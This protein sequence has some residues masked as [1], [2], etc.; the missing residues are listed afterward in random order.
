[1]L[2]GLTLFG[3]SLALLGCL[4]PSKYEKDPEVGVADG[5]ISGPLDAARF[6]L[7]G[8]PP[9]V[10]AAPI[11]DMNL[12]DVGDDAAVIEDDAS[13]DEGLAEDVQ[14][15]PDSAPAPTEC[16]V[17]FIVQVP[18][19][20]DGIYIAGDMTD[21]EPDGAQMSLNGQEARLALTLPLGPTAYKY[22]R[23]SWETV[24]KT[25]E[26]GEQENRPQNI[27][28]GPDGIAPPVIDQVHHW[29]DGC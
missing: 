26:C 24:E 20:T 13:L 23:G 2:R 12:T 6:D 28:C 25:S 11:V 27:R 10:D 8:P 9:P 4:D 29:A 18:E 3:I 7:G 19:G 17:E 15:D 5:G 1:M 21:W 14:P 22:T 16:Q